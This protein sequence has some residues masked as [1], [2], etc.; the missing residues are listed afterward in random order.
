MSVLILGGS[1]F[2]GRHIAEQLVA[3]G[4]RPVMLNRGSRD[5]PEGV[6]FVHG[7]RAAPNGLAGL[8]GRTFDAVVDLSAYQSSWVAD[9]AAALAGH[10]GRYVFISS[11]AVYAPS[12]ELP[13][14]EDATGGPDP[15]WGAYAVEKVAAERMLAG[16]AA[17][18]PVTVLRLPFVLGA[19]NYADR[20][21]FLFSRIAADR[22]ILLPGGGRAINQYVHA[23]DV[24][25]AVLAVIAAP[26][27]E[28]CR[29]YN[30]GLPTAITN[31]G[32][33]ALAAKVAGRPARIRAIDA[34]ALGVASPTVDLTDFVFPFPDSPY[35]LDVGAIA[36][37]LGFRAD[38]SLEE[39]L[40]G[41]HAWWLTQ[42]DRAPREYARES[43]AL[44][45]LKL[46]A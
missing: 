45:A 24:A 33:V 31:A 8:A 16:A 4:E 21:A 28:P 26:A 36:R 23:A 43:R 41:F 12:P 17:K 42:P 39:T 20:E 37:D 27:A 18:F 1:R 2:M 22:P 29:V 40:A 44:A 9:A 6:E 11:G 19:G 34:E 13:W 32:L 3:A 5:I 14:R 10:I 25:R 7:D 46:A 30:V 15:A 35:F 38:H